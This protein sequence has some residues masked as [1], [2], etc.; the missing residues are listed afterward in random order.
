M[1]IAKR[2]FFGYDK[3]QDMRE[4]EQRY[5]LDF[6]QKGLEVKITRVSEI[7]VF[8][9]RNERNQK[10]E[11]S[12]SINELKQYNYE[13]DLLEHLNNDNVIIGYINDF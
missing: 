1:I 13:M 5:Y 3:I 8:E 6:L 9:I 11:I 12:L 2:V 10:T 4:R 7:T